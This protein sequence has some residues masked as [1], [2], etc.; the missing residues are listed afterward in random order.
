MMREIS[1]PTELA[2]SSLHHFQHLT[3]KSSVI[4][5]TIGG[6]LFMLSVRKPKFVQ[7]FYLC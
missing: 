1:R 7:K 2:M 4:T 6:P 5:V 3:L